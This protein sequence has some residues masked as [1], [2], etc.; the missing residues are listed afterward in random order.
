MVNAP[1]AF[2][3]GVGQRAV[4][5][6]ATNPQMIEL[7]RAGAQTGFHVAKALPKSELAKSHADKLVPA[8]EGLY[9]VAT[10]VTAH[11]TAKLLR[12]DQV[13]EL[14]ENQFSSIHFLI[15]AQPMLGE[16]PEKISSRS[17]PFTRSTHRKIQG[18]SAIACLNT[19]TVVARNT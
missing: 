8:G 16:N 2:P 13:G 15:L 7:L 4:A 17:H 5:N 19:R 14:S 1:V 6:I 9:F 10:V 18:I 11:T 3:V 12:V